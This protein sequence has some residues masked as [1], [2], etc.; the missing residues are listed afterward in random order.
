MD[1]CDVQKYLDSVGRMGSVPG[2][3]AI[4]ALL[5]EL[6][7][8]EK[9]LKVIHI[10]GTNGKGS[11]GA[12][13]DKILTNA[14]LT[15]GRY[16]SPAVM[17]PL[18]IIRI[19]GKNIGCEDFS[20]VVTEVK[21]ARERLAE[22]NI[23]PTRFE[24]ETASAFLFF[25]RKK[26]DVAIIECGMGGLL[27]ATNVFE[28]VLCSVITSISMDH[29]DF[30]GDTL[31]KIAFNKA[32]IIKDHCPVV[33]C[34]RD[35]AVAKVIEQEA[36][37]KKA[38]LIQ[39]KDAVLSETGSQE[40]ELIF[41]YEE[42]ENLKCGLKGIYQT[43]NAA[44][45][46]EA[47]KVLKNNNPLVITDGA[48][49]PDGARVL[50][51]TLRYYFSNKKHTFLI[52]IFKDKDIYGIL[53]EIMD[54]ADN[55]IV[56]ETPGNIRAADCEYVASIIKER[57]NINAEPFKDVKDGVLRCL[58]LCTDSVVTFGSLSNIK[59]IKEIIKNDYRR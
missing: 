30:L 6:K 41:S 5:L 58:E 18:E 54:L 3:T 37:L 21:A 23:Y 55:V 46:I 59:R 38:P 25:S 33:T 14:G 34:N 16:S 22:D 20:E 53:D 27:D 52:G 29:T 15:T 40:P 17:E 51:E 42:Y 13:I 11:T 10:A 4:K 35:E 43:V 39:V 44:V 7:N 2:L 12:F 32:G 36:A 50:S 1:Y 56:I 28:K 47:V 57:Y 24:V 19:N 9:N 49:N 45:A 8:P 26:V 31:E 48:H